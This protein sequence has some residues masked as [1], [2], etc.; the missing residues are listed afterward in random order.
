MFSIS[1][2]APVDTTGTPVTLTTPAGPIYGTMIVP[3]ANGTRGPVAL[4][5]AGSGPTDRDG[6]SGPSFTNNSLEFLAYGLAAR[7]IASLRYDKR[8]V[9]E[10]R[11]AVT[12]EEK[13]RFSDFVDDAAGWIAKLRNDPRFSTVIVVGHSEGALIGMMAAAR[14]PRADAFVSINGA[15]RPLADVMREQF[16]RDGGHD[17]LTVEALAELDTLAAGHRVTKVDPRLMVVFRPSVQDYLLSVFAIEPAKE[18][19]R[20]D[21]PILIVSGTSDIQVSV[22]DGEP[23]ARAAPR[24]QRLIV[25]DM[26]HVLKSV[27]AGETDKQ[28]PAYQ[29][30]TRPV[31]PELID[32][33]SR[34]INGVA[35]RPR[36][37][38]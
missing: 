3:A 25:T 7:G 10:S 28:L 9:G 15:G 34:F 26:N 23:L 5:I 30:P 16:M 17:P 8:G 12:S 19:A 32:V 22:A 29:D 33:A 4:I 6:N 37:R 13:L 14:E 24:A 2:P 36:G 20:L 18:I 31:V 1:P 38:S 11:S 21:V 27:P 35:P